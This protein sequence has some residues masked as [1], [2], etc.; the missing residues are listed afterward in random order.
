MKLCSIFVFM[1]LCLAEVRAQ[2]EPAP[3]SRAQQIKNEE[4][5]K[6]QT[7]TPDLPTP[8]EIRF[9]RTEKDARRILQG[10]TVRLQ[11]GGLSGPSPAL[12]WG[13]R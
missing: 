3:A 12:R 10:S 9:R 11:I 7:L 1:F 6:S 2:S 5:A 4:S 13:R 8:L